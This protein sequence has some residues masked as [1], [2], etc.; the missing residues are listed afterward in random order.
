MK[1]KKNNKHQLSKRSRILILIVGLIAIVGMVMQAS[2]PNM[3]ERT[4]KAEPTKSVD[5][6]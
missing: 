2:F 4:V 5:K 6:K 3:H 1:K